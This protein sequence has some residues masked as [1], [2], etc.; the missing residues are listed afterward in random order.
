MR[1]R[2]FRL[3]LRDDDAGVHA[4]QSIDHLEQDVQDVLDPNDRDAG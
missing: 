2:F 4:H 1:E 3:A